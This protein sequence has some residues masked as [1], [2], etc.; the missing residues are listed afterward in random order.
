MISTYPFAKQLH[1]HSYKH[2]LDT[3]C[4]VT[5]SK[6]VLTD[7]LCIIPKSIL[8]CSKADTNSSINNDGITNLAVWADTKIIGREKKCT[9]NKRNKKD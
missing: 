3:S 2:F 7:F 6:Q 4:N 9:W 8:L 5:S 1:Y